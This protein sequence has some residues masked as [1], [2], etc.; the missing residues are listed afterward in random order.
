MSSKW[1]GLKDRYEK[2]PLGAMTNAVDP[3]FIQRVEELKIEFGE[4]PQAD[5]MKAHRVESDEKDKLNE[6][7]KETNA[8]IEAIGQL[9]IDIFQS[10]GVTNVRTEDNQSL[11]ISI[12]PY[13]AVQDREAWFVHV[14][15]HPELDYLW[16][17]NHM[18][19][20]SWAKTLL[21]EGKDSEI[22]PCLK[23]FLKTSI[24]SRKS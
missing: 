1:S 14:E 10:Q 12:E 22:P 18:A 20:S 17:T 3:G 15:A 13:L 23:V 24:R 9:L 2:T 8:R 5:L 4:L 21:E 11:Y 19:M 7:L 16:G 6:K